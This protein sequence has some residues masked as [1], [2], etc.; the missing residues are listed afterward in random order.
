MGIGYAAVMRTLF[1]I[2]GLAVSLSLFAG[3]PHR[4]YKKVN[5]DGTVEYSDKPSEGAELMNVPKGS[6]V[7]LSPPG[8]LQAQPGDADQAEKKPKAKKYTQ[9]EIINPKTGVPLRS[10]NG[11]VS[12]TLITEP[13]LAEGDYIRWTLD[14]EEVPNAQSTSL[15]LENVDRGEHKL[16]ATILNEDDVPLQTSNQ[17]VFFLLRFAR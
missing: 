9:V 1:I 7:D 15:L 6:V 17:V 11:R 16:Q 5:P 8:G 10:N 13:E 2:V 14:G 4:I 3:Q 12:A